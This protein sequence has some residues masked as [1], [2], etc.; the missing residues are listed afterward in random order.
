M[1]LKIFY[2]KQ[3]NTVV[4]QMILLSVDFIMNDARKI[5][6]RLFLCEFK[7]SDDAVSNAQYSR[8]NDIQVLNC[9]KKSFYAE[10]P[11]TDTK[12]DVPDLHLIYAYKPELRISPSFRL[13]SSRKAKSLFG[14][15][16]DFNQEIELCPLS[17]F[18]RQRR[19]YLFLACYRCLSI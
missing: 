15:T 3:L 9:S 12:S 14:I 7:L 4:I 18:F 5:Q 2:R 19:K 17:K 13:R 10:N 6:E 1:I 16:R 11:Q 8:K